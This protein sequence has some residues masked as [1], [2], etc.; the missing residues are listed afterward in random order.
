[1]NEII[2][3]KEKCSGCFA[4]VSTCPVSSISMQEDSEGFWYPKIN[5][6]TCIECNLCRK[7]CPVI[8]RQDRNRKEKTIIAAKSRDDAVR[9]KSSSGG[10]FSLLA[11]VIFVQGGVVYGAAFS[12]DCKTVIHVRIDQKRDLWK[13]QGSKY[14]QSKIDNC[15]KEAKKDLDT[16]RKVLF[17]G[18]PCQIEGLRSYLMKEYDNLYLQDI[19]CH[20]VP[21]P[22]VWEKYVEYREKEA[23]GCVER[24]YFRHKKYGWNMYSLLFEFSN[25]REYIGR[26]REDLYLRGFLANLFLRPSCYQCSFKGL[27]RNSDIT[28]A[29]FWGIDNIFPNMNDDKGISI[30][31]I[32]SEK[33]KELFEKIE[34]NIIFKQTETDS[35]LTVYNSASIK[36]VKA[37]LDR[38]D[39]MTRLNQTEINVLLQEYVGLKKIQTIKYRVRYWL[40]R[41]KLYKLRK[42]IKY[43]EKRGKD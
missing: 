8:S 7:S 20:G 38:K 18:T 14:V 26:K 4:C 35:V 6:L 32:N 33:G 22:L 39:F 24:T 25:R 16:G 10:I 23:R 31:M 30:V 3:E 12:E 42:N 15:Y 19:V 36:S 41:T 28:L 43:Y 11:E 34:G 17:T 29:D 40:S 9:L 5:S 2:V 13:L 37:P 21:S 1:M 27:D